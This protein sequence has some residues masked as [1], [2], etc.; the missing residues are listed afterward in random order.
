MVSALIP[1]AI[2]FI[3]SE[4]AIAEADRKALGSGNAHRL[5]PRIAA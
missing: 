2:D 1:P 5:F 4:P 3:M